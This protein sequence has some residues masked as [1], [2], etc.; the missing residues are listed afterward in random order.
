MLEQQRKEN[1]NN[2]VAQCFLV[3]VQDKE[4]VSD[5]NGDNKPG[6]ECVATVINLKAS[7]SKICEPMIYQR[8]TSNDWNEAPLP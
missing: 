5:S 3:P 7:G 4:E 2:K 8:S 6:Y 1:R